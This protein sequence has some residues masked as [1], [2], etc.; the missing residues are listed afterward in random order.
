MYETL[1]LFIFFYNYDKHHTKNLDFGFP[2]IT[3][4]SSIFLKLAHTDE[5]FRRTDISNRKNILQTGEPLMRNRAFSFKKD[6][7]SARI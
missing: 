5:I 6:G 1:L 4:Q 7:I 2:F 3:N